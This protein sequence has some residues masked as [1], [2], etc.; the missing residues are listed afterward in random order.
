MDA[1]PPSDL[2]ELLLRRGLLSEEQLET[3]L[4]EHLASGRSV[5]EILVDEA[6]VDPVEL[7]RL[8]AEQAGTDDTRGIDLLRQRLAEAE[9]ELQE[10]APTP[11]NE[12]PTPAAHEE[13]TVLF[14]PSPAGY[15]LLLRSGPLPEIGDE[16]GVSGGRLVVVKVGASPLPGD[17]R[18]CAYLEER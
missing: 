13:E 4:A 1:S 8:L 14:V 5:A 2:G 12:E 17:R 7:E 16:I 3:V 9:A 11:A 6:H 15:R 10:G 18:R